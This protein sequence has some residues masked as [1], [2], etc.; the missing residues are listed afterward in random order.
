MAGKRLLNLHKSA[1]NGI[2][3]GARFSF[4][5]PKCYFL[6]LMG[7]AEDLAFALFL[8]PPAQQ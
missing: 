4:Y 3:A 1:N 2:K 5:F 6:V 7:V 8:L